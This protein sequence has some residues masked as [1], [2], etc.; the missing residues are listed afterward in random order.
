MSDE[1]DHGG[2]VNDEPSDD[3]QHDDEQEPEDGEETFPRD[4]V[5]E[6]RRENAEQRVRAKRAD[7]LQAKL[8]DLV[9]AEGTRGILEDSGDLRAHVDVGELVDDDGMPS[10]DKVRERARELAAS[11]PHLAAR[12][13][14][15]GDIGQGAR[16]EPERFRSPRCSASGRPEQHKGSVSHGERRTARGRLVGHSKLAGAVRSARERGEPLPPVA[17][18]GRHH[19]FRVAE[20]EPSE[21]EVLA[22]FG[23][24]IAMAREVLAL[25][26]TYLEDIGR[27]GWRVTNGQRAT[28]KPVGVPVVP[29]HEAEGQVPVI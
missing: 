16:P 19:V 27:A 11:R 28:G 12:Q 2:Q 23:G 1:Q 3:E 13:R 7:E 6:L 29:I 21:A 22:R 5:E 4:Y 9:V 25:D 20:C 18:V 14:P 15:V 10:A 26:V 8:L 24:V 17:V